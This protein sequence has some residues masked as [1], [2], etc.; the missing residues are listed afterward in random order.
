[1][2]IFILVSIVLVMMYFVYDKI[3]LPTIRLHLRNRLFELRDEVRSIMIEEK[4]S[5]HDE[6]FMFV[7]DGICKLLNRL[8]EITLHLKIEIEKQFESNEELRFHT[9]QRINQIIDSGNNRLLIVFREANLVV[10]KAFIANAGAW[11]FYLFP[12]AILFDSISKLSEIAKELVAMPTGDTERLIP[13]R[14]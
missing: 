14:K 12:I 10:E 13:I 1:M 8:P 5:E 7:H 2:S 3:I 6:A 4:R 9:K 11:L